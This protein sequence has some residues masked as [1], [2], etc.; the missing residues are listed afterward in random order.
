MYM[1]GE[2]AIDRE[3]QAQSEA[4]KAIVGV[5]VIYSTCIAHMIYARDTRSTYSTY[6]YLD[7]AR[8]KHLI[9][10]TDGAQI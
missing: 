3:K 6:S 2:T 9:R 8:R 1:C 7:V 5:K 10:S 4:L